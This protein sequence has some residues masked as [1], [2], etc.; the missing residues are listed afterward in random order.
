[1]RTITVK[2]TWETRETI[3]VPDDWVVDIPELLA[4]PETED[5]SSKNADLVDWEVVS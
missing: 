1:M 3:E 5:W 2:L 4:D